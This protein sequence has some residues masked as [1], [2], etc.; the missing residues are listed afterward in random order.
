LINK[1]IHYL[2]GIPPA[3]FGEMEGPRQRISRDS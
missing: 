3:I 2:P 1:S